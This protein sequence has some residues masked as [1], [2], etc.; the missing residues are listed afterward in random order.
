MPDFTSINDYS[1]DAKAMLDGPDPHGQAAMLLTESLLH[2]LVARK[3]ISIPDAIEIVEIA[4]DV[5][6]E[7]AADAEESAAKIQ[8]SLAILNAVAR[9]LASDL[10]R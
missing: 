3:V 7:T 1:A 4:A 9:S 2:G 10:D 5:K 8:K 6:A